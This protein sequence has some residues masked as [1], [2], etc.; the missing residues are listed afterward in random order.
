MAARLP[1]TPNFNPSP[2]LV[3]GRAPQPRSTRANFTN[4]DAGT[5]IVNPQYFRTLDVKLMRGR[6]FEER[7]REGA[8][9]VAIVNDAFV[10][11]FFPTEDAIGREVTVWFA[12]TIIVG[13]VPDFKMNSLDRQTLPEIFWCLRQVS[14]PSVWVLARAKPG[15]SSL[16]ETLRMRIQS[17]DA[18]L[19]VQEMQPMQDVVADSLSL[20]RITAT[21]IGLVAALGVILAGA[22]IY[23]VMSYAVRQRRKEMGIRIAFGARRR[24]V[25][26]LVLGE[27]CRLGVVGSVLGCAVATVI[28]QLATHAV[29][30]SPEQASS[31]TQESLSPAVF[32]ACTGF[33]FVLALTASYVPTR[34]F[35]QADPLL[36]LREE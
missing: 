9:Q 2:V 32:V 26:G 12:K 4:E 7:D 21:L 30:I 3:T 1:L 13:V 29:Y 27:A 31:L 16:G 19:P 5:Q 11:K 17:L 22:G 15:S 6:F 8:A 24:D 18:D 33:L 28:G 23:C 14:A 36:A 25:A 20:K 34:G 35:L 10:R